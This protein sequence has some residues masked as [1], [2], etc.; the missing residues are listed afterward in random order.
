MRECEVCGAPMEMES[1]WRCMGEGGEHDCGD[2]TCCCLNPAI[3]I[4]CEEC[5]GQGEYLQCSELPH[6]EKR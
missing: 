2:D 1:C 4:P 3:N 6:K 5:N